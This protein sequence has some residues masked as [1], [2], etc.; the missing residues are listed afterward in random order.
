[1]HKVT[2]RR[3]QPVLLYS[4]AASIFPDGS[5]FVLLFPDSSDVASL[6]PDDLD[7][8]S[9]FPDNS[10]VA[11]LFPDDSDAALLFPN[12]SDVAYP[13]PDA[14]GI[15]LLL[16]DDSDTALLFR[17]VLA[18]LILGQGL[19]CLGANF[20]MHSVT[21]IQVPQ[22]PDRFLTDGQL[23]WTI[24]ATVLGGMLGC[25]L[26]VPAAPLLGAR[27]LLLLAM[28]VHALGALAAGFGNSFAWVLIGR[29]VMF[30]ALQVSEGSA[31]GYVSEIV[32]PRRRAVYAT[33]MNGL[34]YVG[35]VTALV[36]GQFTDW[37]TLFV[38]VGCTPPVI[39][40]CGVLFFPDSAKW[41]LAQGR[42]AKEARRCVLFF[43]S[44]EDAVAEV[45]AIEQS[46]EDSD[47]S[48]SAWRLLGRRE[49]VRPL[50]LAAT[51]MALF[52]WS[53]G[54]TVLV[55]TA[56]VLDP[57]DLPLNSYQRALV[58]PV[59]A[60]LLSVPSIPLVE[61][62]GRLTLLRAAGAVSTV[63][64]AIIAAFYFLDTTEQAQLGW[65]VMLGAVVAVLP[66]VC[67]VGPISFSYANELLPNK[68]RALGANIVIMSINFSTFVLLKVYPDLQTGIG[69][70]GAFVLHA[71]F[72]I[73][74]VLFAIFCLPETRGLTLEQIQHLFQD[75]E[76]V[77]VLPVY[78]VEAGEPPAESTGE[79]GAASVGTIN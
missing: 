7:V 55:I 35:Q 20:G 5:G 1:M 74:Q 62:F 43:H 78:A 65:M 50:L 37:Q 61:R 68:T 8:D 49:T 9:L 32:P 26:A 66:Y 41:L 42:S 72:S 46:L 12:D 58:I 22:D 47:D 2:T 54:Q 21:L 14:S 3:P 73:L 67:I 45:A 10:D 13:F 63:G 30:V 27:R 16:P 64:C 51:Q 25:L 70:G 59:F 53:G 76:N 17:Q 69:L 77:A 28:P 38:V 44:N 23:N 33:L 31:R 29:V 75:V 39:C 19:I 11:S 34:L 71:A 57:A 40:L 18:A 4:D 48:T 56:I 15:V 60:L 6:F 36:L 24:A 79:D 52:V